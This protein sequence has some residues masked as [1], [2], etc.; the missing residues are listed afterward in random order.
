MRAGLAVLLAV[1]FVVPAAAGSAQPT[2]ES[3][4]VKP[5][6]GTC[7]IEPV[8]KQ[9]ITAELA[10]TLPA[11]VPVGTPVR[12]RDIKL[13]VVFP[14][15]T[16]QA[17]KDK[18][19]ATVEGILGIQLKGNDKQFPSRGPLAKT[20]LPETGPLTVE[21]PLKS[22]VEVSTP[23][24]GKVVFTV[25]PLEMLLAQVKA[26]EEPTGEATPVACVPDSEQDT[27]LGT[28]RVLNPVT[29]SSSA[30]PPTS[31]AVVPPK[32]RKKQQTA[33]E[34]CQIIPPDAYNFWSYYDLSGH[35]EVRKLKSGIDFGPGYLSA[36]L[37]FWFENEIACGAVFGDLLWPPSSGSFVAFGF[38][39][40]TA[41]VTVVPV[42]RAEGRLQDGV[43]TGTAKV[44]LV[45]GNVKVNG[46]PLPVGSK[47][48]TAEPV[49]MPLK[50]VPGEWDVFAGGTI[51]TDVTI[52]PYLGCFGTENLDPL[53][54][55]LI[56]GPGN[57]VKLKFGEIHFCEP[58]DKGCVPP[59]PGRR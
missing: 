56:S 10:M 47:C 58:P 14:A 54:T 59:L 6:R 19:I 34:P 23:Q 46:T 18:Q 53:F 41:V 8:G 33:A 20:A 27:A 4:V 1:A 22:T 35:A 21:V 31:R 52:P 13:K 36:Q 42:G 9:A 5:V 51:E 38:M 26:L 3:H 45:L 28:V 49:V 37:F 57:H 29:S 11:S 40:T 48:Q 7:D 2:A 39:P 24:P 55:G 32:E 50:S 43:F 12:A 17:L 30:A 16:V 44:H 15:E 25:G